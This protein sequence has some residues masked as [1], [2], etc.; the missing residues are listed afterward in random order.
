MARGGYFLEMRTRRL[1][2][3]VFDLDGTLAD[4][5]MDL[6]QAVNA[7]LSTLG[8]TA[9]PM[10]QVM[11]YVG[12]GADQLLLRSLRAAECG[13]K[14]IR[15]GLSGIL[16]S[17]LDYYG[18]NCLVHTHPYSGAVLLLERMPGYRK[19]VLTNKPLSPALRILEG[20]GIRRH[21]DLVIGGDGPHGRKPDPK[22]LGYILS[23][24]EVGPEQ[25]V[26]IGDS[27]QDLHVARAAGCA[28]IAFL[29][30]IGKP[31]ILQAA[32]P[33]FSVH[34]LDQI[35]A[36]LAKMGGGTS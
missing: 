16:A 25:A 1:K 13:E 32:K 6:A 11:S 19:A 35:P 7:T 22:G 28:F 21:F 2:L 23:A 4:T 10:E 15:D 31:E 29:G 20:L 26:M 36:A 30:G 12:D 5:R 34:H 9:L 18:R 17:F 24:L 33:D 3:L 14:D 8:K 27:L